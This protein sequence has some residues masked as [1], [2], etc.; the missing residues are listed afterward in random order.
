MQL[1]RNF[2]SNP[3][4]SVITG[5]LENPKKSSKQE[6]YVITLPIQPENESVIQ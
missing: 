3:R 4:V 5:D 2:T 6:S 1:V